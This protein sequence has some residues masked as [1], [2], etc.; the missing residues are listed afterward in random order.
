MVVVAAEDGT[1]TKGAPDALQSRRHPS[2]G[3]SRLRGHVETVAIH[4]DLG[5]RLSLG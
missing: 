4:H 5:E 2:R 3:P 1:F